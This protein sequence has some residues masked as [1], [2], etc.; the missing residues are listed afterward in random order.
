MGTVAMCVQRLVGMW[1][2]RGAAFQTLMDGSVQFWQRAKREELFDSGQTQENSQGQLVVQLPQAWLCRVHHP[3][4]KD[5]SQ[6][7]PIP[8]SAHCH[9]S[10]VNLALSLSFG[11]SCRSGVG[12]LKCGGWR[13][14]TGT[15]AEVQRRVCAGFSPRLLPSLDSELLQI[16]AKK[17]LNVGGWPPQGVDCMGVSD[18]EITRDVDDTDKCDRLNNHAHCSTGV[19]RETLTN[20]DSC[21]ATAPVG[22]DSSSEQSEDGVKGLGCLTLKLWVLLC[23]IMDIRASTASMS[24]TLKR[25]DRGASKVPK[26][27]SSTSI[28]P[29]NGKG[30]KRVKGWDNAYWACS[31]PV[32]FYRKWTSAEC[33]RLHVT[34]ALPLSRAAL[35]PNSLRTNSPTVLH[36]QTE[37]PDLP[38]CAHA[39][40]CTNIFLH[41]SEASSNCVNSDLYTFYH[42]F[43]RQA[44]L[45]AHVYYTT[46]DMHIKPPLDIISIT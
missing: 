12:N 29:K 39:H 40:A 33:V 26:V 2:V 9:S 11:W 37:L 1:Q 8:E 46:L 6:V 7:I 44:Y 30:K 17:L 35:S 19:L 23:F 41:A 14:Y 21:M 18:T 5:S 25:T 4:L 34:T 20:R 24:P 45:K 3:R 43:T 28:L 13:W 36:A 31:P 16:C 32:G 38:T 42:L 10:G 15:A 27:C 22:A